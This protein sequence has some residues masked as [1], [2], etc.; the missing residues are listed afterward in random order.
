MSQILFNRVQDFSLIE[1]PQRADVRNC[2]FSVANFIRPTHPPYSREVG[3]PKEVRSTG[4]SGFSS[5]PLPIRP[6]IPVQHPVV[7]CLVQVVR[8]DLLAAV[9]VG[10]G[11]RGA[12][13]L[14][15]GAGFRGPFRPST[16]GAF[17]SPPRPACRTAGFDG[18][19]CRRCSGR[20]N[21]S[22]QPMRP[23]RASPRTRNRTGSPHRQSLSNDTV[24][25]APSTT[26]FI[27][28]I[29]SARRPIT[30]SRV[31]YG[32]RNG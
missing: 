19:S 13:D 2:F 26:S 23:A 30:G 6:Q 24:I 29:A 3:Q 11:S 4:E 27:R 9:Q 16:R 5:P 28:F 7:D 20:P 10:D 14:V 31:P 8:P 18:G 32:S 17:S 25:F 22:A 21:H 1:C 15:V 12:E